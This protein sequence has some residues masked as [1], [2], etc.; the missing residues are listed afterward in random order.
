VHHADVIRIVP[1]HVVHDM[2]QPS[3]EVIALTPAPNLTYRGGPLIASVE[4]TT[5]FWGAAWQGAQN[6]LAIKTNQFFDFILTSPLIDQLSEYSV[7]AY[8]I[9]HGRRTATVTVTN[10]MPKQSVSDTDLQQ[11][12]QSQIATN[13]G[14][15]QP[16]ANS[17]YFIFM[18]PGVKVIQG[19]AASCQAFCGYHN[20]IGGKLF[21]GV[22]PFPGCAGCL[23]SLATVDAMTSTSSH[24][25]CEA[26]TD[27]IPGQGWYDDVN[28]EI[29]DICAWKTK[30]MGRYAMQLEW[31]NKQCV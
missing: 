17:L 19:G 8:V 20:H 28:G 13:A 14:I 11:F 25:L 2:A 26:I 5:I 7:S 15:P 3:K 27:P 18:P 9:G 1:L 22:M 16:D 6:T 21:Y 29:G 4:V 31:S 30:K 10:S 12:L 23:G 24:E